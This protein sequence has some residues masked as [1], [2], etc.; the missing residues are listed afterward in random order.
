MSK[1]TLTEEE[2]RLADYFKETTR[3]P[4]DSLP[5]VLINGIATLEKDTNL[6]ARAIFENIPIFTIPNYVRGTNKKVKIPYPGVPYTV[7]AAKHGNEIRGIVKNL[8]DLKKKTGNKG[9]FPN[10]VT[11]DIALSDKVVNVM[12]FSNSMKITGCTNSRHLVD[13]FV[14]IKAL[15]SM[16]ER[17]GINVWDKSIILSKLDIAMENIVFD[18]GFGIRKDVL[19]KK[20]DM[21]GIA[22]PAED[23]AATIIY[24]MGFEKAKGGE[25]YFN[26]RTLHT[27]K[28]VFSGN[29]RQAMKPVYDKF[30][31]FIEKYETDIRFC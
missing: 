16:M 17:K 3:I 22:S 26:F 23:E 21:E 31:D 15:L 24:P 7:L 13:T 10:Q 12:M 8:N 18:L 5:T 30:M 1:S 14:F 4:F 29:N 2:K 28:V 25:R 6:K 19:I 20:A 9:R 11:L 27:G